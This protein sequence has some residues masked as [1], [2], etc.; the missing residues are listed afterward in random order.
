[1]EGREISLVAGRVDA[2][3]GIWPAN[4]GGREESRR[5]AERSPSAPR[6]SSPAFASA[7]ARPISGADQ[8]PSAAMLTLGLKMARGP[9]AVAMAPQLTPA[10]RALSPP[11]SQ[12]NTGA[13]LSP[14][15]DM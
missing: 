14:P 8:T 10:T 12:R 3:A 13:P 9:A 2:S 4:P 7:A 5:G 15:A 11:A 6:R 1:M